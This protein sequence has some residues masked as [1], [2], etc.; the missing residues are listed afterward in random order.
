[1]ITEK[2]ETCHAD[3]AGEAHPFI[4]SRNDHAS[5]ASGKIK[6]TR[7]YS[8]IHDILRKVIL[9]NKKR[10]TRIANMIQNTS[11]N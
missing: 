3:D 5:E 10:H 11:E 9:T 7:A 2:I 6:C 8:N 1:M 4:E